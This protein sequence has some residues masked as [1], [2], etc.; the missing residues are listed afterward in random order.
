MGQTAKDRLAKR[1]G[2]INAVRMW[3]NSTKAAVAL[4]SGTLRLELH[5][6]R[7]QVLTFFQ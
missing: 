2:E 5:L 1:N 6:I 3:L 7:V 4:C